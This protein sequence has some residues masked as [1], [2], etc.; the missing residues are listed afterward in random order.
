MCVEKKKPNKEQQLRQTTI[1]FEIIE[2]MSLYFSFVS[3]QFILQ[4]RNVGR[5]IVARSPVVRRE[6]DLRPRCDETSSGGAR[7]NGGD[8]RAEERV[9]TSVDAATASASAAAAA[10]SVGGDVE[11]DQRVQFVEFHSL[12][13]RRGSTHFYRPSAR[14]R[15]RSSRH[16]TGTEEKSSVWKFRPEA[17][18]YGK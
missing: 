3:R 10:K 4:L 5:K 2:L 18:G 14:D 7:Q 16:K 9:R 11:H 6:I 13:D 12:F 8:D 1:E 15:H 17:T